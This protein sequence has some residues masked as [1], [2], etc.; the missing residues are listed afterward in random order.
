MH[1]VVCAGDADVLVRA[2]V[3]VLADG[4]MLILEGPWTVGTTVL[5]M[6]ED[7]DA[8]AGLKSALRDT[9][10]AFAV[11]GIAAPAFGEAFVIAAHKMLDP[12]G[13]RP[14]AEAIPDML[15][16]F[17]V[18]SLARGGKVTPLAGEMRPDRGVVLEFKDAAAAVDF[19]T[20]EIYAPLL[21]LRLRTTDPRFMVMARS[22]PI[23]AAVREAARAHSDTR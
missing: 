13:F 5:G 16:S 4:E 7:E 6:V 14:Y 9:A 3:R 11:E 23:P 21:A 15:A 22:G 10:G 1:Y 17:G 20:S 8:L 19:Y 18:R 12:V 2:G